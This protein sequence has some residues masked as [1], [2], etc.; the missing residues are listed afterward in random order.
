MP[1]DDIAVGYGQTTNLRCSRIRSINRYDAG[2]LSAKNIKYFY[3][4]T[5]IN[6][7]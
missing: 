6:S 1:H 4:L 3:L 7:K 2:I 5:G